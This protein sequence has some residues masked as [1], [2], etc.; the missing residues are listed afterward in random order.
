MLAC[1]ERVNK[2]AILYVCVGSYVAFWQDFY[3]SFEKLFLK[4]AIVEYYVFTDA[5]KI[6]AEEKNERIHR[7]Y[8]EDL[9]WP[10][11]T[12]FRFKIF[13]TVESELRKFDYIFFMNSNIVCMQEITEEM[14]LPQKEELLVVQHPGWFDRKPYEYP[15]DRNRKSSAY[16]PKTQ[17]QIYVCGGVNGGKAEAF[18][19][20]IHDLSKQIEEDYARGII[21]KWHDESQLNKYIVKRKDYRLLSPAYCYPEGWKIPFE[22]I[23]LV[24]DKSKVI[25]LEASKRQQ[26]VSQTGK[27]KRILD[28]L[29]NFFWKCIYIL[30]KNAR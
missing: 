19:R 16:I 23:L 20:V 18:L 14:F 13:E 10:G 22:P 2:I 25:Q 17:G 24:R 30:L 21:A 9:G 6:Y 15:Y 8:Q 29:G 3:K 27:G 26:Q 12:L 28:R 1:F 7:K 5:D 11:N 4:N